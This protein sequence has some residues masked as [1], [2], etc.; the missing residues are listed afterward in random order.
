MSFD[1]IPEPF[2]KLFEEI[3]RSESKP[4]EENGPGRPRRP[5]A[6]PE[7]PAFWRNRWFWI[8]LL[9]LILLVSFSSLVN[10]YADWLWFQSV[11][12]VRVWATQWLTRLAVFWAA[13]AVAG[14]FLWLNVRLAERGALRTGNPLSFQ[15]A[16]FGGFNWLVGLAA[17][18]LALLFAGAASAE[19]QAFLLFFNRTAATL[20]DP[21]FKRPLSF[22]FFELPVYEFLRGWLMPLTV[23]TL[24]GVAG[25]YALHNLE[26]LRLGRWQPQ[27]IA[28]LRRHAAILG[29]LAALL[30]AVGYWLNRYDLLYS[31][32]SA[33]LFG[34][35]YADLTVTARTLL[36]NA[37]LMV[38][39]A[40]VL[41]VNVW[42][43]AFRP[44]WATLALWLFSVIVLNGLVPS[45]VQSYG[46]VPNEL[47]RERPYL[48][49]NIDFTRRGFNL[50]KVSVR[51]FG[52]LTDLSQADLDSNEAAVGN[53]RLWDYRVLPKNYEQLQAL[54]PYYQFGDVDIDRYVIDGQVRQVNLAA[55]ELNKARLPNASWVNRK[56][57]FTHGY[58]L[59]MSPI[60]RFTDAGQPEFFI[61]D[62]PP[63]SSV[64]IQ[65]TR[66]EIYF[67]ELTNDEVYVNSAREEFSYPSGSE[68]VRSRYAGSGGVAVNSILR[69]LGLA[70]HFGDINLLLSQ[71][72]TA[73]TRALFH[74]NILDSVQ[75]ITP[76]LLFDQDPYLVVADGRLVWM[77]DAYTISQRMPYSEPTIVTVRDRAYRLNYIR[78]AAKVTID[79]Y[80]G[81]VTYYMVDTEDPYTQ[82]YAAAFPELFQPLAAMPANLQAHIRYPETLF[83]IQTE[84]YLKYHM[85][86]VGVFYNQ[87]DLWAVP[88]E[89]F[90]G[91]QAQETEPYYIIFKLPDES[92]TEYLLIRPYTPVGK[93]NMVAWMAA[94]NDPPNY[95]Q[96]AVYLLPKKELV[97]GP[98]QVEGRIDQEPSISQ[99]ISLWDQRGSSVIRGNMIV[100][101]LNQSFLYV[102]PLYLQSESSA[103]PELR[104]VIVASGSRVAMRETLAEALA[105]LLNTPVTETGNIGE[106][107]P[108]AESGGESLPPVSSDLTVDELI[109][110]ANQHFEAAEAAQRAG[111][112]ATYG[113]E[114]AALKADLAR[115]MTLTGATP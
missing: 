33:A 112:W 18:F 50:D 78:N 41:L 11:D 86:D 48:A 40:G 72:V 60:D 97:F 39:L 103:L 5:A 82:A 99:Q 71:D 3:E 44:I 107:T 47:E 32:R 29:A 81:N 74:R 89:V 70:I 38:V 110:S 24:L 6:Q 27:A 52:D 15:P 42:R 28:P 63:E 109:T 7:F 14:A 73:D 87:E 105:A 90:S 104:R 53:I 93:N 46:V 43:P 75:R 113:A 37:L 102:E 61:S 68:N 25:M 1:D 17:G 94:R 49:Y 65:V 84:Q 111:D 96:V 56:L 26:A 76:F 8:I 10:L 98:I 13:F 31:S 88:K 2:R 58:G 4:E 54:R 85:T 30:A 55:R 22:Y 77:V 59:V 67:G 21:I 92:S 64:D 66:P 36:F 35:G 91:S 20:S 108:P 19:W 115:L 83:R 51:E 23:V 100:I 45:L 62:L 12:F 16:R 114:L 79:A 9:L 106:V 101:P 95:G 69:R 57:E 34:A 80:N